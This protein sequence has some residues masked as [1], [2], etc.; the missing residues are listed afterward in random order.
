M[1]R[2]AAGQ[3]DSPCPSPRRA[4][5]ARR[6]VL[7]TTSALAVATYAALTLSD[8]SQ[9]TCAAERASAQGQ[10]QKRCGCPIMPDERVLLWC[11]SPLRPELC[12]ACTVVTA[13]GKRDGRPCVSLPYEIPR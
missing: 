9:W 7:L 13:T 10:S 6:A 5:E 3:H 2:Q 1:S 11:Q 8:A 4:R 12:G